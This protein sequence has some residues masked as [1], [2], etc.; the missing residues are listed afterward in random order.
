MTQ[1]HQVDQRG[2]PVLP[3]AP[4]LRQFFILGS[5][6]PDG[7]TEKEYRHA[8]SSISGELRANETTLLDDIK[9]DMYIDT[10]GDTRYLV[11]KLNHGSK[12]DITGLNRTTEVQLFCDST[13]PASQAR[14]NWITEFKTC[15]YM[16][17]IGTSLLCKS[18]FFQPLTTNDEPNTMR[19]FPIIDRENAQPQMEAYRSIAEIIHD[20]PKNRTESYQKSKPEFDSEKTLIFSRG[21]IAAA[22]P[23]IH[24]AEPLDLEV[25]ELIN[26]LFKK[27]ELA[28]DSESKVEKENPNLELVWVSGDSTESL[29]KTGE[30]PNAKSSEP[31]NKKINEIN[32]EAMAEFM[33]KLLANIGFSEEYL[34]GPMNEDFEEMMEP[35][36][37][38]ASENYLDYQ[39]KLPDG[40][41][42]SL[43]EKSSLSSNS[44][45]DT[46]AITTNN[47]SPVEIPIVHD[48]L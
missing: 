15:R 45:D 20:R 10:K 8:I 9:T 46:D 14:I 27:S 34:T 26:Q 33:N 12:C 18:E 40:Q 1:F 3:P 2:V 41:V 13:V 5:N 4:D 36:V 31:S 43:E 39:N 28:K 17:G 22:A 35:I 24:N 7:E 11:Q 48:E 21:K 44:L 23:T 16:V 19:C 42:E 37:S 25:Q 47:V 29:E 32:E 6:R 38:Q 30:L